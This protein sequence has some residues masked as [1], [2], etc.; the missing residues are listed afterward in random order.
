MLKNE[1][2][3]VGI[4]YM[5]ILVLF[6][7]IIIP[8]MYIGMMDIQ[9]QG[10]TSQAKVAVDSIADTADRVY[11]QGPGTITT[12][13]VYLPVG[14][15]YAGFTSHEVNINMNL[16]TGGATDVYSLARGNLT[17]TMPT[18]PG[19]HVLVVS[20]NSTGIVAIQEATS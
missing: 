17:G 19:R 20:M 3:Q 12:V 4:E 5:A 9:L 10:Q 15:N 16:P 13:E 18:L 11:A 1:T 7:I 8:V 6:L 14:I 2:G